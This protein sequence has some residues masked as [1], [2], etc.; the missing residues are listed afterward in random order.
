MCEC[1]CACVEWVSLVLCRDKGLEEVRNLP[2]ERVGQHSALEL[3][4]CLNGCVGSFC[5][6]DVCARE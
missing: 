3:S 2:H 4:C 1:E 6:Y 5:M